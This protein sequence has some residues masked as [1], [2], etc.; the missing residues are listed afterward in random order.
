MGSTREARYAGMYPA[1]Q[2]VQQRGGCAPEV[3]RA[4][5]PDGSPDERH[6]A[7]LFEDHAADSRPIG[8]E[9]HPE[10]DFPRALRDGVREDPVLA[11]QT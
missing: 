11:A 3:V 7:D 4:N 1:P 2:L 9:R 5:D 8:A 6:P 10:A